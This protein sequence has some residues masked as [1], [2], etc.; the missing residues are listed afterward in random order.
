MNLR[1]KV[2]TF[3]LFHDYPFCRHIDRRL[4]ILEDGLARE[5]PDVVILQEV[6]VSRLYGD[7]GE[8]LAAGLRARGLAYE[9]FYAP[10]NGSVRDGGEF[11]EGSAILSRWPIV[12]PQA[13]RLA[14]DVL[15]T[16][17]Y[18]GYPYVEYRIAVRATVAVGEGVA[19]DV[20]G[21]HVTDGSADPS[22]SR[23][24]RLQI[25]DLRRFVAER[26]CPDRPAI[27]GGDLNATPD[28]EEIVFLRESGLVDVCDGMDLGP[29]NDPDDRDLENPAETA[30]QRIDYLWVDPTEADVLEVPS[31]RLF[32]A[33]AAEVEPGRFLWASDHNGIVAEL[34]LQMVPR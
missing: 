31:A 27:L 12:D 17:E 26:P 3:N 20:F 25:E 34:L 6:S 21:A 15:P 33:G 9:L 23:V 11:E 7:L 18:R 29:T 4:A 1:I 24:R 30:R 14:P 16:R 5:A 10:A 22:N 2:L 13:R 32:L 19:L 28:S 8:R